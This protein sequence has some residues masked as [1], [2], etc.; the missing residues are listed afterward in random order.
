MLLFFYP[1][2]SAVII[3]AGLQPR[4]CIFAR[5]INFQPNNT[6]RVAQRPLQG[7]CRRYEHQESESE[8]AIVLPGAR[9]CT[10]V[11]QSVPC[12]MYRGGESAIVH[13]RAGGVYAARTRGGSAAASQALHQQYRPAPCVVYAFGRGRVYFAGHDIRM[14]PSPG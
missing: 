11:M 2:T 4:L 1:K 12:S 13:T 3:P 10:A 6:R 5:P 8:R 7:D 9:V 14:R